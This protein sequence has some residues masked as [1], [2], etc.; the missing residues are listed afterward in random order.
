M[1][2][3]HDTIAGKNGQGV[4]CPR[5][6]TFLIRGDSYLTCPSCGFEDYGSYQSPRRDPLRLFSATA[7]K[8]R[9]VGSYP[10]M[11]DVVVS[12]SF[13]RRG[14][15]AVAIMPFCPH[16]GGKMAESSLSGMRRDSQESRYK[17]KAGHRISL[18]NNKEGVYG[19]Q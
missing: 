4:L 5:C 2:R 9:Y 19:W 8:L 17:C 10:A 11:K 3:E 12:A 15:H 6:G 13:E 7:W 16:C 14:V 1:I 18:V